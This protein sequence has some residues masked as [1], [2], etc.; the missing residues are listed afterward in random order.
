MLPGT[1]D[2]D[3]DGDEDDGDDWCLV[4]CCIQFW[5]IWEASS[6]LAYMYKRMNTQS[7]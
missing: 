5:V 6:S 4:G 3:E 7:R 2:E 1:E